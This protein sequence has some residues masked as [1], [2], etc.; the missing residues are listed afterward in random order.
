MIIIGLIGLLL[1]GLMRLLEGLKSVQVALCPLRSSS[2]TSAR[3]FA[4]DKGPLH[5]LERRQLQ[6]RRRRVRRRS[7]A[8]P[9]AA[10]STLLNIV[11]GFERPTRDASRSMARRNRAELEGHPDLPARLGLSLAHRSAEPDV[12]AQRPR[13]RARRALADHY[14]AMVGLKGFETS[15]PHEL[16][17]GMLKRAEL[18]RAL[19]VK[20]EILYMD[21]P[22]SALDA[23][24]EPA[25]AH[26]AAAH[27]RRKSGIP[28]CS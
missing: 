7:S 19:V 28:S 25:H 5:V 8:P 27:S 20:P 16:S 4:S 9:A 13:A 12:R 26:R 22:F 1:D 2:R 15:Y 10:R 3:A 6:R 17:G 18:A 11:A 23:L 14:A 24:D 21:E